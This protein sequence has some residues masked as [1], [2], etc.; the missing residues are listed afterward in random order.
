MSGTTGLLST[1]ATL[2]LG[3]F[4]TEGGEIIRDAVLRYRVFGELDEAGRDRAVLVFHALTGSAEIETWWEPVL[5]P[6]RVLDPGRTPVIAANLLGSCYGSSGPAAVTD[7]SFPRL[8]TGDLARAHLPLLRALGVRRLALVTGGSLG[9]MV[10]LQW[11]LIS[12]LPVDRLV[13]FG[14]PAVASAQAIAWNAAQRMAIEAD[15]AWQGGRYA[16]GHGP[17]RKSVV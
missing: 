5:G 11:G 12:P 17:D 13:V 15:P 1:S 16:S 3:D 8:T 6:G 2:A 7:G 14:A 4:R 9:G 10:A